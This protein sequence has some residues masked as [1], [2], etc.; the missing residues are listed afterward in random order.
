MKQ[1]I[2]NVLL[3]IALVFCG[4]SVAFAQSKALAKD[5][6]KTCKE[7]KKAGWSLYA[8]ASTM[9]YALT[10]YRTYVEADPDNHLVITGLAVG[11]NPKI[12][13]DNAMM[14]GILPTVAIM[15]EQ[16]GG[17]ILNTSS[18]VS[19]CGQPGGVAYPSSKYAVNGLT[20][21]LA[22]ELGPFH[23]RVNAVA[24]GITRTDMVAALPKE[25]ID[26]LINR[27]PLRR[28]GEAEDIANA[29]LFLASDMASYVTG[30]ILSV[31]GAMRS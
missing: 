15:K 13:R 3:A 28:I 9:E 18:M 14:N 11:K 10:K 23:I 4:T 17:C 26:P 24:P 20:W 25:M 22:R 6:K 27:I 19:I 30:E 21:S 1:R 16:G 12:G 2:F 31:D 29:F 7:W 8:T 5:V